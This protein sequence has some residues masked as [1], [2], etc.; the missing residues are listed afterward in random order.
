MRH[1]LS[2]WTLPVIG[3]ALLLT[4]CGPSRPPA[5]TARITPPV[6]FDRLGGYVGIAAILDDFVGRAVVDDRIAPYFRNINLS[7][8]KSGMREFLCAETGGPCRYTGKPMREAHA[9]L[10]ISDA[11]FD[12]MIDDLRKTLN[13]TIISIADRDL[14][15]LALSGQRGEVVQPGPPPKAEASAAPAT[16][17]KKAKTKKKK[18]ASHSATARIKPAHLSK[19]GSKVSAPADSKLTTTR[20]T[21]IS[22]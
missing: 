17:S 21:P 3:V 2:R 19:S 5:E 18:A 14:V 20:D 4:A 11:A 7:H 10:G 1:P 6:L 15:V 9:G 8:M 16:S 13:K 12:A 22:R